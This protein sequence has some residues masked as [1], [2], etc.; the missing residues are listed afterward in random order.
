MKRVLRK[1]YK[2]IINIMT[3]KINTKISIKSSLK[4]VCVCV[5]PENEQNERKI[6]LFFHFFFVFS[7]QL[8]KCLQFGVHN[9]VII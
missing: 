8:K 9:A 3:I 2:L 6:F 4:N 7:H 5:S 1:T